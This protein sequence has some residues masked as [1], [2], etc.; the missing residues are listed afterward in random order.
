MADC[1][2]ICAAE[3]GGGETAAAAHLDLASMRVKDG[4][5]VALMSGCSSATP[6]G[7]APAAALW[8]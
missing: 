4:P 3:A 6:S 2:A 1:W 8:K 5:T 7:A